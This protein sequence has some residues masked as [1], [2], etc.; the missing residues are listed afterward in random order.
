MSNEKEMVIKYNEKTNGK[1]SYNVKIE[2]IGKD[3]VTI[4]HPF[5][6]AKS[7]KITFG[8]FLVVFHSFLDRIVL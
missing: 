7:E 2:K 8:E 5:T 6:N 3:Y 1:I 4:S